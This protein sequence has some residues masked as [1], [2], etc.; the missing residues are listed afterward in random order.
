[1]ENQHEAIF[2]VTSFINGFADSLHS[3]DTH[4]NLNT[5]IPFNPIR[6]RDSTFHSDGYSLSNIFVNA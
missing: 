4:H 5:C 6:N 3:C 2:I 1:L